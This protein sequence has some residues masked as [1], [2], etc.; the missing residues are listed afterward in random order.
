MPAATQ[1]LN[2]LQK[3]A[4]L[5]D[6]TLAAKSKEQ[7]ERDARRREI[8]EQADTQLHAAGRASETAQSLH[9]Q[10]SALLT[11][12]EL[13]ALPPLAAVAMPDDI[14]EDQIQSWDRDIWAMPDRLHSIYT[15]TETR[16][17]QLH[18]V[19]TELFRRESLAVHRRHDIRMWAV[20]LA[21]VAVVP[22]VCRAALPGF[23]N[24]I[25]FLAG[26]AFGAVLSFGRVRFGQRR[27]LQ[28]AGPHTVVALPP[29]AVVARFAL[30]E[31]LAV[32]ASATA[33]AGLIGWAVLFGVAWHY[34]H[35]AYQA[36]KG[37]SV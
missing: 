11:Q 29:S 37:T 20:A 7:A 31:L 12:A 14:S 25:D 28:G 2:D 10:L 6:E 21:A 3:L 9:A 18:N 1:Y 19:R 26:L 23:V 30:G 22:M 24:E 17:G 33:S 5:P 34:S 16:L 32:L 13:P 27:W 36:R 8:D 4:R 35:K 15:Q